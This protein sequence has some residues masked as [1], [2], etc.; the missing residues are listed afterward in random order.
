MT[1]PSALAAIV[2]LLGGLAVS[3]RHAAGVVTGLAGGV[4]IVASRG[5]APDGGLLARLGRTRFARRLN[6]TDA[7][8]RRWV[9]AGRPAS[10]EAW[11]GKRLAGAMAA[12][13]MMLLLGIVVRM[14]LPLA[15]L[16]GIVGL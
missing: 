13:A 7:I 2:V 14:V 1:I 11:Q 3:R 12:V 8:H 5:A 4:S 16:A 10:V 6:W 15:P 9:G